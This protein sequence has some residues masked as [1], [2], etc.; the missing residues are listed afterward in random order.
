[1]SNNNSNFT[2]VFKA[3]FYANLECKRNFAGTNR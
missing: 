2:S 1:M 3:T